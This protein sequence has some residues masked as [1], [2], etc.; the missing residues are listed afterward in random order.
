VLAPSASLSQAPSLA[1][2]YPSTGTISPAKLDAASDSERPDSSPIWVTVDGQST[3]WLSLD[4]EV[5]GRLGREGT[6][7]MGRTESWDKLIWQIGQSS[8]DT[9]DAESPGNPGAR[10]NTSIDRKY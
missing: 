8:I 5:V 6:F 3:I 1:L 10:P 9:D 4:I 7:S 2:D